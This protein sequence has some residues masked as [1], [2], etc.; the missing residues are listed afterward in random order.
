MKYLLRATGVVLIALIL[1]VASFESFH[2][3]RFGHFA[4]YGIHTDIIT[5]SAGLTQADFHFVRLLNLTFSTVDLEGCRMGGGY[6]GNGIFYDFDVQKWDA[7]NRRWLIFRGADEWDTNSDL[8]SFSQICS[9]AELTHIRPLT[10]QIVAWT[11]KDWITRP[12]PIRVVVYSS[13]TQPTEKQQVYYSEA[14]IN[15]R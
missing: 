8:R 13:L 2:K 1:A 7:P 3:W 9:R 15:T 12:D 14:F 10:S 6:A 5:K 4:G 11:Y